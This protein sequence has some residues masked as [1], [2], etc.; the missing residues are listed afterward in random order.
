M[1]LN[2]LQR[3]IYYMNPKRIDAKR[4]RLW[5]FWIVFQVILWMLPKSVVEGSVLIMLPLAGL[6]IYALVSKDVMESLVMGTLSMY[7]MWHKEGAF[8][9]F[10][11]DISLNLQDQ[12]TI[13]MYMSFMLCGGMILALERSG[14]MKSFTET[15]TRKFGKNEKL[16]LGTSAVYAGV[17]SIDDYV[18]A[19]TSG[20]AFSGLIESMKRPRVALAF[21]VRTFSTCVSQILPFGAWGYFVIYQI[22]EAKN[23]KNVAEAADIFVQTIPYMFFAFIACIIAFLFAIGL[24]PKIGMMKKAYA[25][26]QKGIQMGDATEGEEDEEED[27][28]E[29]PRRQNVSL[30]NLVLPMLSIAFFLVYFEYDA[31]LAFGAATFIT[32][33]LFVIQGIF[34]I[35]EYTKCV[36]DGCMDMVEMTIILIIGYA[37]QTVMYDMG[38][39][40]FVGQVC[41]AIPYVSLIPFIFFVFF[42]C[43]EY[44]YSLNYTLYQIAIPILMVVLPMIGA[45]IPLTLGAVISAS[46]FGANACVVSDAGVVS[47]KGARVKPYAQYI[48]SQPYFVIA[49]VITAPLYLIAGFLFPA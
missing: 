34:T 18:S 45:N 27:W 3:I 35:G 14:T 13:S 40:A 17:M 38:M 24:F 19:L 23:V 5:I 12:E 29:D 11:K 4:F 8:L 1:K 7:I 10:L 46:L 49:A 21:V 41:R 15:V 6:F 36:V 39:E 42:S 20:A 16:I 44:L 47:A 9:G 43:T 22:A 28:T 2:I 32:G 31:F 37:M 33:V 26:A 30:L 48:T 25:M